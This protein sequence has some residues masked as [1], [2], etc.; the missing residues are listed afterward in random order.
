VSGA[1]RAERAETVA[2]IAAKA[3]AAGLAVGTAESLTVG[4]L[5][6]ALGAGDG[7]AEWFRGG[8]VA[9]ASEVKFDVLGVQ[10]GPVITAL[11]AEQMAWGARRVLGA[12][13]A[14]AV[15]GVGGPDPEEG[16]PPGTVYVAV[17]SP[18]P[19]ASRVCT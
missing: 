2:I 11:C 12:D 19:S 13:V 7:A 16:C 10:Q 5:A 6:Q 17:A 3:T 14:V 9:Y 8:V 18:T 1:S 4:A 15:T